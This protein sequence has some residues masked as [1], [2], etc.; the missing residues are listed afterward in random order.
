MYPEQAAQYELHKDSYAPQDQ[1]PATGAT[2]RYTILAY[3]N[4]WRPGDGGELRLHGEQMDPRKF[5]AVEPKA[6]PRFRHEIRVSRDAF[7][8]FEQCLAGAALSLR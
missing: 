2:R 1:D 7:G 3:F 5:R 6:G 8:H 4:D